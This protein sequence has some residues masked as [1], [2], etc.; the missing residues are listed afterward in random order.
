MQYFGDYLVSKGIIKQESLIDA[1]VE[2]IRHLPSI[3]E[4]I[5]DK[6]LLPCSDFIKAF[7]IQNEKQFD[8]RRACQELSVWND[9][10]EALVIKEIQ[11]VRLPLGQILIKKGYA[12]L[13]TITKALDEFLSKI[14]VPV[15]LPPQ[16]CNIDPLLLKE[17]EK[18]LTEE[19]TLQ[20]KNQFDGL[21]ILMGETELLLD[22][23]KSLVLDLHLVRGLLR[24]VRM[25]RFETLFAQLENYAT[26]VIQQ[27]QSGKTPDLN[28]YS[29]LGVK[30]TALIAELKVVLKEEA[31]ENH[32]FSDAKRIESFETVSKQ[33]GHALEVIGN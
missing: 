20:I 26:R 12:D 13:A 11:R 6:K 3:P 30:A 31:S 23:I 4:I 32:W 28:S 5:F 15:A 14:E 22:V 10:I 25:D 7:A 17:F 2:Q 18:N 19:K 8:F 1:L 29:Q 21:A 16:Q 33:L 24:C 27:L 9:E